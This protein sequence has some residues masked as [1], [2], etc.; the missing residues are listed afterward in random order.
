M[1]EYRVRFVT[2]KGG[3]R[4]WAID[5]LAKNAA[6]AKAKAKAHWEHPDVHMFN[7]EAARIE[8][9]VYIWYTPLE[10]ADWRGEQ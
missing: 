6:E 10:P 8:A 2:K 4:Y 5:L 7:L 1:K 9:P 3:F